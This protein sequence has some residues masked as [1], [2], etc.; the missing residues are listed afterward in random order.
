LIDLRAQI[1]ADDTLAEIKVG[2]V[3]SWF[4]KTLGLK[5]KDLEGW[6]VVDELRLVAN[7]AK[8]AEGD[9]A[10]KL[11]ALRPALFVSESAEKQTRPATAASSY[12]ALRRRDLSF[13]RGFHAIPRWHR[14]VL[15]RAGRRASLTHEIG[16]SAGE[17][18]RD[19]RGL[20]GWA[21]NSVNVNGICRTERGP[22]LLQ[23]V[24]HPAFK[25]LESALRQNL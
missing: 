25:D 10:T 13:R 4:E 19:Q 8:H 15:V 2:Q 14:G 22:Q 1:L 12:D 18:P 16:V 7:V 5:V 17:C 21:S 24:A 6:S 9:S 20:N 3:V 23:L 11:R